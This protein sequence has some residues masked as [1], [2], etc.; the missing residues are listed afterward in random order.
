[1]HDLVVQLLRY[2]R[3]A[4]RYR[5]WMLSSAWLISVIGWIFVANMPDVYQASAQVHVDTRSILKPV[6]G[7]LALSSGSAQR[8]LELIA[9]T[10]KSRPNLEKVM[11]MT[12]LDLQAKTPNQKEE[13]LDE[14]VKKIRFSR[15]RKDQIYNISYVHHSPD[16]AKLIVKSLLTI[17]MESNLGEER[18]TQDT[19]QEFLEQ[20]IQEYER[21][22]VQAESALEKFKKENLGFLPGSTGGYYEKLAAVKEQVKAAELELEIE[23]DRLATLR[24]QLEDDMPDFDMDPSLFGEAVSSSGVDTTDFDLRISALQQ[25]LDDLLLRFTEK[26]PEVIIAKKS[27]GALKKEKAQ[28]VAEH[29]DDVRETG[30]SQSANPVTQQISISISQSEANYAAKAVIVKEYLKRAEELEKQVDR[31]LKVEGMYKQL[32]RDYDVIKKNHNKLLAQLEG[33]RLAKSAD[34]VSS[35]TQFQIVEPPRVPLKP[36]GPPRALYASGIFIVSLG[37]GFGLAFLLSQLRPT[38]DDRQGLQA[39]LDLP[40]LGSVDMVWTHDQVSARKKRN[41]SFFLSL[42]T[43][44]AGY[45]LTLMYFVL[46]LQLFSR[47]ATMVGVA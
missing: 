44:I 39:A 17:F 1:M 23:K 19:Q 40:V 25:K 32:N 37:I 47:L 3:G 13:L 27:I 33:T 45:S 11:R 42:T 12:D 29:K 2:L 41:Y 30:G 26:H 31:A 36:S 4:W 21:R 20:Q 6:L 34:A 15:G 35:D 18:R 24:A 8:E 7:G 22:L 5:W 9:K 16:L 38:F 43:L 28:Y 10:I 46:D 14:L